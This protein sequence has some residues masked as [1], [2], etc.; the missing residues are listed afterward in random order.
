MKKIIKK[1]IDS[2]NNIRCSKRWFDI[3]CKIISFPFRLIYRLICIILTFSKV[4]INVALIVVI[5]LCIIGG[6][7][8]AKFLPMYQDASEQ[9]YEQLSNMNE[10]SFHMLSTRVWYAKDGKKIGEIDCGSYKYI[11]IN[12]ISEDTVRIHRYRG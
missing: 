12:N 5:A 6:I 2:L 9:A 4:I 1:W 11:S 8:Y 7:V 10:S 3:L